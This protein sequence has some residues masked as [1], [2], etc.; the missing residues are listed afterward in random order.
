MEYEIEL[1]RYF[2][3]RPE[4]S[5][6]EFETAA[7]IETELTA[8]GIP[9]RRIG[10]TGVLGIVTG[11]GR[12]DKNVVMLRADIDALRIQDEKDAPYRSERAGVAHVCGHD[13]H[14]AALLGAARELAAQSTAFSGEVRLVFQPGEEIGKGAEDFIAAGIAEGVCRVFGV[15]MASD[16]PCGAIGLTPGPNNASADYF[17]ITV[18][19]KSAHISTP[20]RGIDAIVA[21]CSVITALQTVATRQISPVN[22]VVIGVGRL[23]AGDAY[24]IVAE[25][26][27]LEGTLRVL[28]PEVRAGLIQKIETAV[29]K[30]AT[31]VGANA[32]IE[33]SP[34]ASPLINPPEICAEVQSLARGLFGMENIIVN[35]PFSFAADNFA[36]F[37]AHIPGVYAYIG[38]SNAAFPDT[39]VAHHNAHFDIDE[40][41]ILIAARLYAAYALRIL[42]EG[43]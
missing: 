18:M 15:H 9:H 19:G 20:E 14:T 36:V 11:S 7:K 40:R 5:M 31:I 34:L 3:R 32:V 41:S 35:R 26:A 24:N 33:W 4:P 42:K 22:P 13:A 2:H 29:E 16:L 8:L 28:L 25:K 21:A 30:A 39:C 43:V 6:E 23:N 38:S 17:K 27:I 37:Q 10:K 1:R 12:G